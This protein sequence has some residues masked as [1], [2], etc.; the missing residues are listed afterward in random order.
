MAPKKQL[1][2]MPLD[3]A[4]KIYPAARR[5]NWSNVYRLSMTLKEDVDEDVLRDA[6]DVTVR[7]FPSIAARLRRGL[8]WYYLE[9]VSESPDLT[10]ES[11][12]PLVRMSRKEMGKCAFR[13]IA[14]KK[15][16]A[17]EFF[18]ALT[19]GTGGMIFIKSLVAEYLQQKHGISI[20]AEHGIL[21]RQE[22]PSRAELEDS[23][24]KYAGPIQAS[25]KE[26]DAWNPLAEIDLTG[27][28]HLTCFTLPVEAVR[29][30]AKEYG[31][32]VTVFLGAVMMDALQDMQLRWVRNI[33]RRKAIKVLL[34]V[35]LRNLFPSKSLRNFALYS[36]PEID[37]RLGHY[38]FEEICRIIRH[39]MG[40]DVTAKHMSTM[41]ATN[42]SSERLTVVRLMPLF[43][44]NIVMKAVF[45]A[46]GER[47]SCLSLS[48][49]GQVRLPEVMAPYIDRVD[50]ILGVQASSPYN[51]G[52]VSWGDSLYVNFIR[53]VKHSELEAHFYAVLR[54]LG[55][56]ATVQSNQQEV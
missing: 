51:C 21:D 36:I 31:V 11:S 47:K 15:R 2:W 56:P 13:V 38:S 50:F 33:R 19:D 46:V 1:R 52:V 23:F 10:K 32:S 37:P 40:L 45:D 9:Q 12:Y 6:L 18:H 26:S 28:K 27:F 3:N 25:R 43:I 48:N 16:I 17:V 20:P 8:F 30:K 22:E 54:R 39:R 5:Q 55:I 7:R 42:V 4:A 35:N 41:I 24:Q 14:Y 49:L 53:N 34:P 29:Q 44:K